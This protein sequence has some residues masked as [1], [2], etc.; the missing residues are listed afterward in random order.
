MNKAFARLINFCIK[1]RPNYATLTPTAWGVFKRSF[2]PE[3]NYLV[4]NNNNKEILKDNFYTSITNLFGIF[5]EKVLN[6][7]QLLGQNIIEEFPLFID[8]FIN[9]QTKEICGTPAD[10]VLDFGEISAL[11]TIKDNFKEVLTNQ[12]PRINQELDQL[13]RQIQELQNTNR[14]NSSILPN[15]VNKNL[16]IEFKEAFRIFQIQ[17]EKLLRNEN[18]VL[19]YETHLRK[20]TVPASLLWNRF[21]APFLPF[22][23]QF[24]TEYN[25]IIQ[26]FQEKNINLCIK[27]CK[28]RIE[29]N[30]KSILLLKNHYQNE[31][32][33]DNKL[34]IIKNETEKKLK[35]H[36]DSIYEKIDR[37][38]PQQWKVSSKELNNTQASQGQKRNRSYNVSSQDS[39]GY[40]NQNKRSKPKY[41]NRN[42]NYRNKNNNQNNSRQ[43]SNDYNNER[44]HN[45]N[46]SRTS[47]Q[48]NVT[49]SYNSNNNHSTPNNNNARQQNENRHA[50]F[51]NDQSFNEHY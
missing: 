30:T 48:N 27:F 23:E 15:E 45:N 47:S 34:N 28:S 33:I 2:K 11:N 20:K 40:N 9:N 25:L 17:Y 43:S 16:P 36:F 5:N 35:K 8:D 38:T 32:D 4:E 19:L 50:H 18:H 22:D 41:F 21:P 13:R 37:Y 29:E 31:E 1:F 24:V 49:R 39:S 10:F 3:Y 7:S 12:N 26:E 14:T 46:R 6:E 42:N 44:R 51:P